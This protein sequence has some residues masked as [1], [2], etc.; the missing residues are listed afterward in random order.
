M[1]KT[2]RIYS[3][4]FHTNHIAVLIIIITL[5]IKNNNLLQQI[6]ISVQQEEKCGSEMF[7]KA[8]H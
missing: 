4:N 6:V 7:S 1:M 8:L 3:P 2:L 5:Y